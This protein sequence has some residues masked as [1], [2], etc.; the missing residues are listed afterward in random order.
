MEIL[1]L[2]FQASVL[3]ITFIIYFTFMYMSLLQVPCGGIL[4]ASTLEEEWGEGG[5]EV[6]EY[7][8]GGGG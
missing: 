8:I 4:F 2:F 7:L 6:G 3:N 1:A 5:G